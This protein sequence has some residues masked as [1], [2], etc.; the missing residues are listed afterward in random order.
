MSKMSAIPSRWKQYF[1]FKYIIETVYFN[2]IQYQACKHV[3]GKRNSTNIIKNGW[4]KREKER[5]KRKQNKRKEYRM[6][7]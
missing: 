5:K 6:K 4:Q 7:F 2:H 3:Y 1:F